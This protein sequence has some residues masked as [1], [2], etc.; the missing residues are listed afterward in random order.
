MDKAELKQILKPLI[1]QCI[2]EVI[3]EEGTLSTIISEVMKGTS[4]QNVVYETKKQ[5]RLET[6]KEVTSRRQRKQNHLE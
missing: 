1:K 6:E 2:K 3:F 4:G 5:P